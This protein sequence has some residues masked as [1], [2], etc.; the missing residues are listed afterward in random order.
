MKTLHFILL[1]CICLET[2]AQN[3]SI[4]NRSKNYISMELDPAPFLLGGY[5]FSLK[6]SPQTL[7][8]FTF[9]GSMYSSNFPDAMM[10]K[11]N[12]DRGFRELKINTSYALFADYFIRNNRS[13]FHFG[14]SVFLYSKSVKNNS[15]DG[16]A[17]FRSIYPNIRA[18]YVLRPFKNCGLYLN[19]W[20][21]VGKELML[22]KANS[23]GERKFMSDKITYVP[24]IHIGYQVMF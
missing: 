20:L 2:N 6:F 12:Y 7:D 18:G 24:A 13:G 16:R 4:S 15:A 11:S 21:N 5:S 8:H 19:P 10:S 23:I 14:P 17:N 22:S 9:M 3:A 1:L